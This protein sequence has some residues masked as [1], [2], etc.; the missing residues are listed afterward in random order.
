MTACPSLN[1]DYLNH[2]L[3]QWEVRGK[4][5]S[6][7]RIYQQLKNAPQPNS[8]TDK[9]KSGNICVVCKM[10]QGGEELEPEGSIPLS[11]H[12]QSFYS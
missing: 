7:N 11:S 6:G 3:R 5:R 1:T 4:V 9:L 2:L 12:R 8:D 10:L